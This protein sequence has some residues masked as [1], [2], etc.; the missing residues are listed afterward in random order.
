M[1]SGS[2]H[3]YA[4]ATARIRM[5][6]VYQSGRAPVR[7]SHGEPPAEPLHRFATRRQQRGL[8]VLLFDG[9]RSEAKAD[10]AAADYRKS[11]NSRAW[12]AAGGVSELL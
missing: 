11:S 1:T 8:A 2:A 12:R 5:R 7:I 6:V 9:S 4:R 10:R 3:R